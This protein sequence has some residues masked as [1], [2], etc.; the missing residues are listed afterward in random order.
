[1]RRFAGSPASS[2][3]L[4]QRQTEISLRTAVWQ[5]TLATPDLKNR[6]SRDV[7]RGKIPKVSTFI[8]TVQCIKTAERVDRST[9]TSRWRLLLF[10]RRI[11]RFR[12]GGDDFARGETRGNSRSERDRESPLGCRYV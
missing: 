1:M 10:E 12:R 8:E 2:L 4:E 5:F 7:L 3:D 11:P 9:R 6:T